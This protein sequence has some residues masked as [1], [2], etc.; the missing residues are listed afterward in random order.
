MSDDKYLVDLAHQIYTGEGLERLIENVFS[1]T[2]RANEQDVVAVLG[3]SRCGKDTLSLLMSR[4]T[5]CTYS[6]TCSLNAA[7][8]VWLAWKSLPEVERSIRFGN[9]YPTIR[10]FYADRHK[11]KMFWFNFLNHLRDINPL[12]VPALALCNGNILTGVRS[13]KEL[14]AVAPYVKSC[15]WVERAGVDADPTLEFTFNDCSDLFG[16]NCHVLV[17]P[18]TV[19]GLTERFLKLSDK[20]PVSL[21][22]ETKVIPHKTGWGLLIGQ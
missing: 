9:D 19:R 14:Q 16:N 10:H 7:Q 21:S 18:G 1:P 4:L 6:G 17:N 5:T 15:V 11:H 20:L 3:P 22:L 12:V 8:C 13:L 2:F